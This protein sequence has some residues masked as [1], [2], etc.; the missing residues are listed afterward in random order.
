[1]YPVTR[2]AVRPRPLLADPPPNPW[3]PRLLVAEDDFEMRRLLT[4]VLTAV[5]YEVVPVEDGH[6]LLEAL[7]GSLYADRPRPFDL[8]ISDVRMPG[9]GGLEVLSSLRDAGWRIPFVFITAF[10]DDMTHA[11]AAR[12]G[13]EVLDKP[14]DLDD[15]LECLNQVAFPERDYDPFEGRSD[16]FDDGPAS[17]AA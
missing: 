16:P 3:I 14:F 4:Q 2:V 1:M 13:S 11:E 17:G 5:G 10:G 15:L 12:L 9:C 7:A 6:A 8:V